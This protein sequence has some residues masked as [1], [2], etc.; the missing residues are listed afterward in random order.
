MISPADPEAYVGV[1]TPSWGNLPP[2]DDAD[3]LVARLAQLIIGVRF[4]IHRSSHG[5]VEHWLE[6]RGELK[7]TARAAGTPSRLVCSNLLFDSWFFTCDAP[8]R[9]TLPSAEPR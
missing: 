8:N 1:P 9:N 6:L 4:E 3:S 7:K 5:R 2:S